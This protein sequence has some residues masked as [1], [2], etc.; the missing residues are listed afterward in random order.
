MSLS[1][2]P[3]RGRHRAAAAANAGDRSFPAQLTQVAAKVG[4]RVDNPLDAI[5]V[6]R[7][8]AVSREARK[9]RVLV[10]TSSDGIVLLDRD[11]T[12]VYASPST[13]RLLERPLDEIIG[14]PCIEFV[15]PDD[16]CEAHSR[17]V[18]LRETPRAFSS[19][20]F[21]TVSQ[22]GASRWIEAETANLLDDDDVG[23]IVCKYRDVTEQ[24]ATSGALATEAADR[25]R[26][27]HA[28][29]KLSSA[30]EQ[31]ADS[32]MMTDRNGVI[33][34]VNPAFELMTGYT[35]AEA[36]G[37]TPRLLNSGHQ[38]LRFYQDLWTAI[39]RGEVMRII[40]TNKTKDGRLYDEDQT[41]TPVRDHAGAVTHFVSTGRDITQRRRTQ[42]AL[43][44]LN[45]Q[46]EDESA[47]IAGVLHDEA[48]Q[49]LT[50]AHLQLADVARDVDQSTRERLKEV[51]RTLDQVEDQLRRLS[52]EIHP[53][54]VEDL[55][56]SEAVRFIAGAFTR[57]TEIPVIV[58]TSLERRYPRALETVL[59][60]LVQEGLTNM[61]RH[62][63]PTA[64]WI[65]LSTERDALQCSIRDDG[66]G[67]DVMTM[68][69]SRGD[70][71]LGL[72]V[73]QDRLEA[74]GGTLAIISAPGQGTELRAT[75]PLET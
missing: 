51:R 45:Q 34:Y 43:R 42:E 1:D 27:A 25:K 40:V 38:S 8:D 48:G 46:L 58:Q 61:G 36:I 13:T 30:I 24:R 41:I 50:A 31:T 73:V 56:L 75:V 20:A 28:L 11:L 63:R 44:R 5:K 4:I 16:R 14:R 17:L 33:E 15:H 19:S 21:R 57:R 26:M 32:V 71:G 10:E 53:R 54:V 9:F 69:G 64:G 23:A 74:I 29:E 6:E 59:Y 52:H 7:G 65:A 47:R 68:L 2:T 39:L 37:Q 62:A 72:R 49:F 66:N 70:G 3:L 18:S 67:F 22:A 35:R 12:V 55:G 60:R